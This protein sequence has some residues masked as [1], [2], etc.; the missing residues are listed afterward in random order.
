M[1]TVY[2]SSDGKW[3]LQ[4][5]IFKNIGFLYYFIFIKESWK[6]YQGFHKK[7]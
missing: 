2:W 5:I 6:K 3:L 4:T 1:D 7:Y